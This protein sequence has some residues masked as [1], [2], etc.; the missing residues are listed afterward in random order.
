MFL[1][2]CNNITKVGAELRVYVQP[3]WFAGGDILIHPFFPYLI[4]LTLILQNQTYKKTLR[5]ALDNQNLN[6]NSLVNIKQVQAG[7][8]KEISSTKHKFE[9]KLELNQNTSVQLLK[10]EM[11]LLW[12]QRKNVNNF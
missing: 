2:G 12:N 5:L 6:I 3:S 4:C 1:G 10:T 7:H 8:E 9:Q 11:E